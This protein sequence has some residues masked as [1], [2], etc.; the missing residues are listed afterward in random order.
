[1]KKTLLR[2]SIIALCIPVLLAVL[3]AP[4]RA[5]QEDELRLNIR[6]SFGYSS[7]FASGKVKLQGLMSLTASGPQDLQRVVFYLDD[8]ILGEDREPPF[9]LNFNTDSYPLGSHTLVAIGFT[10]GGEELRSNEVIAEFVSAEEG[11]QDALRIV[12]PLLVGVFGILL[13]SFLVPTLLG[14]G[15][16]SHIPLGTEQKYGLSGGSICPRCKRPFPLHFFGL[17]LL[18]HKLDRC[19]HCGKWSLVRPLP[20]SQ[21]RAAE[22]AELA[23]AEEAPQ[24]ASAS[25]EEKL[26]K[27][28]EDSRF[29]SFGGND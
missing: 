25:D 28:L 29:D 12:G 5:L 17:N 23:M 26:K 9:K 22:Q 4:A 13:L 11:W 3:V 20:L 16:K 19:P 2:I 6:K 21:L 10:S 27:E 1:M 15:K 24:V 18:T 8:T 7:G 14:R